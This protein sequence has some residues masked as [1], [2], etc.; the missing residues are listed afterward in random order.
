MAKNSS[1]QFSKQLLEEVL[2]PFGTL[3]TSYE[4]AG[5]PQWV[6]VFFIPTT[7][8]IPHE[9][10]LLG[11]IV[12]TPCLIEP[13]RNQ[14]TLDEVRSCLLKLLQV[15]GDFRRQAR[16]E[17][18]SIPEAE[19]PLLWILTSSASDGLLQQFGT[20][21]PQDWPTGVYF[22]APALRTAIVAINQLPQNDE[23][24]WLR[25][26]GKGQTQNRA[27]EEVL[28]FDR[29]DPRRSSILRLLANWK[30]SIEVTRQ[31][32][33]EEE[34]FLMALSQ[35]YL[36]WEQATEQRGRQEE[37]LSFVLRLLPHR[38]GEIP[39]EIEAHLRTLSLTQLEE[40]GEALLSFSQLSDLQDWLR[41]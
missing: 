23:T 4:V 11:R 31:V 22:L 32:E 14:P 7:P 19:L 9:L 8:S 40:L 26:L 25:L 2:S 37:G 39:P 38:I 20:I 33:A 10:G 27:I 36:E 3:E 21:A 28:A 17:N 12:Q 16:R 35:A 13:F 6:D 30:V 15:H 34:E 29:E 41:P 1:D 18:T 5:E 24:L